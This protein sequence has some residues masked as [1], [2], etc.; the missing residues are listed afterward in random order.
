MIEKVFKNEQ[1]MEY[2][3]YLTTL[4]CRL[5]KYISGKGM[6]GNRVSVVRPRDS[7]QIYSPDCEF[8]RSDF[9]VV[10]GLR[11]MEITAT[12]LA[13]R[14]RAETHFT[15]EESLRDVLSAFPSAFL[16]QED[17]GACAKSCYEKVGKK[18]LRS[19]ET[20]FSRLENFLLGSF[21]KDFPIQFAEAVA[22]FRE[23]NLLTYLTQDILSA[24]FVKKKL[25]IFP[26]SREKLVVMK[27][28]IMINEI[29][30]NK[31]REMAVA[32]EQEVFT[33]REEEDEDSRPSVQETMELQFSA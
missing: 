21:L 10:E 30:K 23:Q 20:N 6:Y 13:N 12:I 8:K 7:R 3:S 1:S 14:Q 2:L 33:K 24:D 18:L 31:E 19:N 16:S 9:F 15:G 5:D 29:K 28:Q 27:Q 4:G 26:A 22:E 25:A 32:R 17:L 11:P